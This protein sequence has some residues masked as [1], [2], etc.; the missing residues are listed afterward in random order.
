M[1]RTIAC[2]DQTPLG[3]GDAIEHL[4]YLIEAL[5]TPTASKRVKVFNFIGASPLHEYHTC[6]NHA[7]RLRNILKARQKKYDLSDDTPIETVYLG[8]MLSVLHKAR[9]LKLIHLVPPRKDP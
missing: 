4:Q 5:K 1:R 6:Y 9:D 7:E 3:I 8:L 2:D